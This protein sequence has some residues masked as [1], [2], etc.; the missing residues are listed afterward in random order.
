MPVKLT[1][2]DKIEIILIVGDNYKTFREAAI[3]FNERHPKKNIH[4]T[5]KF[6]EVY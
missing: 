3:I 4:F 2:Q 5:T 6:S 1:M